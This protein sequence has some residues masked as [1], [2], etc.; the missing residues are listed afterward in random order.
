[1]C[2]HIR[3]LWLVYKGLS[4]SNLSG[5]GERQEARE[6]DTVKQTRGVTEPA[7]RSSP[8]LYYVACIR[9]RHHICCWPFEQLTLRAI[10]LTTGSASHRHCTLNCCEACWGQKDFTCFSNDITRSMHEDVADSANI[11]AGFEAECGLR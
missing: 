4:W 5:V 2:V 11:N 7:P 9:H 10:S 1:M 6:S 3:C 8:L